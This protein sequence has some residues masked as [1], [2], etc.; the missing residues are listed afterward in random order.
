MNEEYIYFPS[1]KFYDFIKCIYIN[2]AA[3]YN[4]CQI[5]DVIFSSHKTF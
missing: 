2:K 5:Q 1:K 3:L 4:M